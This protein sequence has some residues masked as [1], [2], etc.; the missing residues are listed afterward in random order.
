MALSISSIQNLGLVK[1]APKPK[2]KGGPG[3]KKF[4]ME[5]SEDDLEALRTH[6]S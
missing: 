4:I 3:D 6:C 1:L 2:P 5:L